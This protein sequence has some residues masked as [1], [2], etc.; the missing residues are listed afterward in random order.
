MKKISLPHALP[1][2]TFKALFSTLLPFVICS[3]QLNFSNALVTEARRNKAITSRKPWLL[4][5]L[6]FPLRSFLFI[7]LFFI[8]IVI[9]FGNRFLMWQN[10]HEILSTAVK[11]SWYF[12]DVVWCNDFT[13]P[14]KKEKHPTEIKANLVQSQIFWSHRLSTN[15]RRD[16]TIHPCSS[17][18]TLIEYF[19]G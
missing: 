16:L 8:T 6:S 11:S 10:W 15:K 9:T 4:L 2:H 3:S 17:S 13:G 14:L 18:G 19:S 5:P 12:L 1:N 7:Y